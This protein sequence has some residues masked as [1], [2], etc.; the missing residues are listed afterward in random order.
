M[1]VIHPDALH[2]LTV[3]DNVIATWQVAHP[4]SRQMR[5]AHNDGVWRQITKRTY[6]AGSAEPTT[7]QKMWAAALHAGDTGLLTGEYA[8]KASGWSGP[9]QGE[10]DVLHAGSHRQS[11]HD[12]LV[13]HRIQNGLPRG[14]RSGIPRVRPSRAI[15]DACAT[16]EN[17]RRVAEITLTC[18]QQQLDMPENVYRE[19]ERAPNSKWRSKVREVVQESEDGI[20]STSELDFAQICR[21]YCLREPDRQ[22]RRYDSHGK[23]RKIDVYWDLESVH[24]EIDGFDHLK[25]G[26]W[27]DDH[28][29]QNAL[30]VQGHRIFLRVSSWVLRYEPDLFMFDLA[31]ALGTPLRVT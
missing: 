8:L 30:V 20:T 14:S 21:R 3:Q 26:Q 1:P 6:A 10:I 23:L 24:V 15:V 19:L 13:L 5:R 17:L 9:A 28:T 11:P 22:V 27:M 18:L 7:E 31:I 12:W 25:P 29:R 4:T 2:L 16:A